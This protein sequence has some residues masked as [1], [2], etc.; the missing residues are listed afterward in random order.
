M[1]IDCLWYLLLW[2][3][4]LLGWREYVDGRLYGP[5][6]HVLVAPIGALRSVGQGWAPHLKRPS[7]SGGEIS[8]FIIVTIIRM[9]YIMKQLS[10]VLVIWKHHFDS[11]FI[12][13]CMICGI[14]SD[15][16]K[17]RKVWFII[18]H[19]ALRL[20]GLQ[21]RIHMT[22]SYAYALYIFS[23]FV[24]EYTGQRW[25][26]LTKS[27]WSEQAV[28]ERDK[29][30][31]ISNTNAFMWRYCNIKPLP[32]L[33]KLLNGFLLPVSLSLWIILENVHRL[34]YKPYETVMVRLLL[35]RTSLD[36]WTLFKL[37]LP[38]CIC[39]RQR[40]NI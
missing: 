22:L 37:I 27:C 36:Y 24:R 11:V 33:L 5:I 40:Y 23:H 3:P 21:W 2:I 6:R 9:K 14:Y 4:P 32:I 19:V 34:W 8:C 28:D 29:L 39:N 7:N 13:V 20:G 12:S 35:H 18:R 31:V 15:E 30:Q 16:Y 38:V 1:R 25:I 10:R 26:I 17:C